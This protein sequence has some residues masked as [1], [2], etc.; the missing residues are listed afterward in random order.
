MVGALT[1]KIDSA[2]GDLSEKRGRGRW[3]ET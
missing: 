2:L 3:Y 1:Y